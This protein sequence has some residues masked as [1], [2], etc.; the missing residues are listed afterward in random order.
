NAA[1]PIR[2]ERVMLKYF[3]KHKS[4]A[5]DGC[6]FKLQQYNAVVPLVNAVT[7]HGGPKTAKSCKN[8]FNSL[9]RIFRLIQD[10]QKQFGFHWDNETGANID[11]ASAD[12]WSAYVKRVG[13][14]VKPFRNKGWAH[15]SLMEQ[16]MPATAKGT[17]V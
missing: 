12:A 5:G 15:L 1:W 7:T 13:N 17:H 6:S 4:T 8:K 3:V 14:D 9:K 10:I 2:D 11:V 16:M